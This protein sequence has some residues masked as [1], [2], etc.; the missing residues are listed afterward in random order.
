MGA[1]QYLE[2]YEFLF[3][4]ANLGQFI[5]VD[6]ATGGPY[7]E[8]HSLLSIAVYKVTQTFEVLGKKYI[9]IKHPMFNVTAE[10]LQKNDIDLRDFSGMVN[11]DQAKIALFKFLGEEQKTAEELA[12]GIVT[13][14]SLRYTYVGIN[15]SFDIMFL[16]KFLTEK[17]YDHFFAYR[18]YDV[19][20]AFETLYVQGIVK[21][22]RSTSIAGLAEALGIEVNVDRIHQPKYAAPLTCKIARALHKKNDTIGRLAA[23][24]GDT[25]PGLLDDSVAIT[26]IRSMK[27]T[28]DALK[29][30]LGV[31]Q[32][33]ED[34]SEQ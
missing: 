29:H 12:K 30:D 25:M 8:Y 5:V 27:A 26:H 14:R 28:R 16:K 2:H 18:P 23:K 19:L 24:Y 7:S 22:P 21:Q 17:V 34:L 11:A 31:D 9:A 3:M 4:E 6:C 20:S 15:P 33:D 1:N 32:D 10:A 13:G